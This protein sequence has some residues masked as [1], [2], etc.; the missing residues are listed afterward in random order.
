M[1]AASFVR[2]EW[3]GVEGGGLSLAPTVAAFI[4]LRYDNNY[5]IYCPVEGNLLWYTIKCNDSYVT[6]V[7]PNSQQNPIYLRMTLTSLPSL[8]LAAECHL[9]MTLTSLLSL[10]LSEESHLHMTLTS[11][12]SLLLPAEYH[13]HMTLTSFPFLPTRSRIPSAHDLTSLPKPPR[14][15]THDVSNIRSC[16]LAIIGR[17][18]LAAP[19]AVVWLHL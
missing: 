18:R 11:L 10:L 13:L 15:Y 8:L 12:P 19:Y 6:S 1:S 4:N 16:R 17:T 2:W 3:C 9:H 14:Q 7:S 5:N